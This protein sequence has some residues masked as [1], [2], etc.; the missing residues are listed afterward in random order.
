MDALASTKVG[1]N[2]NMYLPSILY[3]LN[4]TTK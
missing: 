2:L 3:L 1:L 4:Q